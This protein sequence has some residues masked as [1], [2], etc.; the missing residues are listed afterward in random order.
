MVEAPTA[1]GHNAPPRGK[2]VLDEAGEPVYGPRDAID[3]EK[4]AALGMP[5]WLAGSY[6][7]PQ[8]LQEAL[9]AR[10]HAASRWARCSR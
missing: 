10:R 4:F 1:G 2:L 3:T 7:S 6:G 5:F 8:R 9:A